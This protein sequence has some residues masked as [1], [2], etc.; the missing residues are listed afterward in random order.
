MVGLWKGIAKPL[1]S[2]ALGIGVLAA[3]FHYVIK[4]P[5]EVSEEIEKEFQDE[6]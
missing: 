6:K 2:Y 1:A 3:F 5:N 4:G